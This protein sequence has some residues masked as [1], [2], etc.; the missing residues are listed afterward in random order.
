MRVIVVLAA[1]ASSLLAVDPVV[2]RQATAA[3]I[4]P[5]GSQPGQTFEAEILGE[6]LDRAQSV[7]FHG[8]GISA[9]IL[10]TEPTRLRLRFHVGADASWGQHSFQ[11]ITPR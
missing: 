3:S 1:W 11:V 9:D 5:M 8:S 2:A 10:Q 6:Y 4:F 7:Y